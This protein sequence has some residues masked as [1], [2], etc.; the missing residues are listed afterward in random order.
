MLFEEGRRVSFNKINALWVRAADI[1]RGPC[2]GLEAGALWHP[3][4]F[5]ALGYAWL[6]SVTLRRA[7][8]RLKRYIHILSEETYVKLKDRPDGLHLILADSIQ[9]PAYM[10]STMAVIVRMCRLNL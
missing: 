7:L 3:S 6:A 10:D 1:I 4:F 8:M 9:P 2:F 5:G